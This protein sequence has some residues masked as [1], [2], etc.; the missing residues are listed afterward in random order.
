[1]LEVVREGESEEEVELDG[2]SE[3]E[4]DE[5]VEDDRVGMVKGNDFK[6]ELGKPV[7]VDRTTPASPA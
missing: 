5:D 6:V 3:E 4:V 7:N 1:M 2:D